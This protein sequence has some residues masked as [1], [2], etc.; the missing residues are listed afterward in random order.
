MSHPEVETFTRYVA[1]DSWAGPGSPSLVWGLSSLLCP[2]ELDI[3]CALLAGVQIGAEVSASRGGDR[4]SVP[5]S[6]VPVD[7]LSA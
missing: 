1:D 4:V 7:R 3:G 5:R 2:T 6:L